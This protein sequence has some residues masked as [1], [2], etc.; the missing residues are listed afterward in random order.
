M[1]GARSALT[2][3]AAAT[4]PLVTLNPLPQR[5]NDATPSFSGSASERTT[6][7]IDVYAGQEAS[8]AI[9]ATLEAEGTG[10]S[11]SSASVSPPLEDGTYTAL[12]TQPSS[13]GEEPGESA[14]V[15]FEIDT[16]EPTVTIDA[17]ATRSNN[18]APSFAGSAS[19]ATRVTVEVFEGTR[20]EGT[21][22]AT[23]QATG[24]R[25]SWIAGALT[26]S[27]R[28]GDHTFTAIA[29]QPSELGNPT[30]RSA[31]VTFVVDTESPVITLARPPSP[32]NETTPT[33]SGTTSEATPVTI[34]IFEGEKPEGRVVASA[35]APPSGGPFATGEAEPALGSGTFTAIAS[36]PSMIGNGVGRSAP[37][38][39][40]INTAAPGVT[41]NPLASPT[42]DRVPSFS[43]S[44][45]DDTPV[46]VSV[47]RGS[48]STGTP[49]A[50]V[51]AQV[52]DG[53]WA[54]GKMSPALEWGEYTALATQA[55]SLGNAAGTSAPVRFTVE[56]IGPA[57]TTEAAASVARTSAALYASVDP[58]GAG[59]GA[60][61]FEYGAS[62][63]YG[64]SIECGLTSGASA[65][66]PAATAAVPVFVRIFGLAPSTTYHYRIVAVGEGGA[67]YGAD[68][69]FTTLPPF[70]F[71]EEGAARPAAAP[72]RAATSSRGISAKT[73]LAL[74]A[75]QLRARNRPTTIGAL[76]RAG[77]FAAPFD[78]P[79]AGSAEVEW[80]YV[81]ERSVRGRGGRSRA[82]AVAR[83]TLVF[84][85]GGRG[86][87]QLRLTR[88]G[89]Q[90]LQDAR[91]I[92]LTET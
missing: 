43:G 57:V 1:T 2:S 38:T 44:A 42:A 76:L 88:R 69:T 74:I 19:E 64:A 62:R 91:E 8:G 56:P 30:G 11:W 47:Y 27:L 5:S 29:T 54:T 85:H 55:S 40:S 81:P 37:V 4:T 10:A 92:K 72:S 83:G 3:L 21:I 59:V 6:V 75:K 34:E 17:P 80:S 67:S 22:V 73:L 53:E 25:G 51:Q 9:V 31:P 90:L 23:A 48:A 61:Y 45:S 84:R 52:A 66:P 20:P 50:T 7:T 16:R 86:T 33:F 15:T 46:T 36:A 87:I 77:A 60:C 63:A 13:L 18:T 71:G 28:R 68:E 79:E 82:L 14:P 35:H 26:P 89:R 12:A 58:R 49:L 70:V 65:F 78:A 32:S 24:T 39:F 41:L